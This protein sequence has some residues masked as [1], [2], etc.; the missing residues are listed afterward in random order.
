M[1]KYGR[2][3]FDDSGI[4]KRLRW[5]YAILW[6][7]VV[8]VYTILI[9]KRFRRYYETS[10]KSIDRKDLVIRCSKGNL[11]E[12]LSGYFLIETL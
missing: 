10:L 8:S 9:S 1:F 7:E 2:Y 11:V 12:W 3:K 6:D 5:K 4:K